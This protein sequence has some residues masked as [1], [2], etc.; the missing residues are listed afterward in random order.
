MIL[1]KPLNYAGRLWEAGSNVKGQLPMDFILE[2][3]ANGAIEDSQEQETE[4]VTPTAVSAADFGAM[5]AEEQKKLLESLELT[6]S[7]NKEG[8]QEQYEKWLAENPAD[9]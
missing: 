5:G 3:Q 2:L 4:G 6:A 1:N 8:R 9:K 7:S